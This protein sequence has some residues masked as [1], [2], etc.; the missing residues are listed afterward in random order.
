MSVSPR[1]SPPGRLKTGKTGNLLLESL[2]RGEFARLAP[3]LATRRTDLAE[4]LHCRSHSDPDVF[5][6]VN[7]VSSLVVH[8][9]DGSE[10]EVATVGSEGMVGLPVFIGSEAIIFEAITQVPGD[11][12]RLSRKI[13]TRELRRRS[14]FADRLAEYT[15]A[16]LLTVGQACF[17]SRMHGKVERCARWLLSVADRA[18]GEEFPLTQK[19]LSWM[20]GVRRATVTEAAREL[21]RRKLIDYRR[22]EVR[23][24][25]RKGLEAAACECYG[26]VRAE[27]D[28]LRRR[29]MRQPG[30]RIASFDRS[31]AARPRMAAG[32]ARSDRGSAR[33]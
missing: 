29:W 27:F 11:G 26:H 22:G 23:V 13:L 21:Q 30:N 20:I 9:L 15:E 3:H 6:P 10:V 1:K 24:L 2:P 8:G 4:E 19:F 16:M 32:R 28:A 5:F 7:S 25:D 33:R 17:C 12:L 14:A 31:G 18:P